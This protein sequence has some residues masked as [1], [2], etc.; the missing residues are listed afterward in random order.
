MKFN[1]V[2]VGIFRRKLSDTWKRLRVLPTVGRMKKHK[3]AMRMRLMRRLRSLSAERRAKPRKRLRMLAWV[4]T[5][6][7]SCSVDWLT[8]FHIRS[9]GYTPT[10]RTRLEEEYAFMEVIAVF[11]RAVRARV[12]HVRHGAVLLAHYGRLGP[13]FD[14]CSKVVVDALRDE[15]IYNENG[16]VVVAVVTQ[17]IR[18]VGLMCLS[19]IPT[20]LTVCASLVLL[21]SAGPRRAK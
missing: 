5:F 14:I 3:A 9:L 20:I 11:L 7:G 1:I 17:A 18:D 13:A 15:G 16:E 19:A 6:G 4:C 10:S 21:F 12:V 8:Y 2:V